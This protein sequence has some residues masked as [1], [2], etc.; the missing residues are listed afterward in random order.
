M[1]TASSKEPL[2]T[3]VAEYAARINRV[4]P[5][6]KAARSL[7]ELAAQIGDDINLDDEALSVAEELISKGTQ[8]SRM[9]GWDLRAIVAGYERPDEVGLYYMNRSALRF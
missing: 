6:S 5:D 9:V 1:V 7:R 4:L 8:F 3:A 2:A